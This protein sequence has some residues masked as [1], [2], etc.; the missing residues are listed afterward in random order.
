MKNE[1][2]VVLL[3][4][5][6]SG[7]G[8]AAA[9]LMAAAGM[10]VYA[11]SRRGT[12]ATES[13][14]IIPIRLDVNDEAATVAAI[15]GIIAKSG[16]LDAVVVN[17]GNG[18]AGAIEDTDDAEARFQFETCFFGALKTIRACLPVFRRQGH[19]RILTVTSV[20]AVIPIPYQGLYSSAKSAL[21][22]FTESLAIELKGSGI[23]CGSVLPGD[24]STGFTGARRLTAAAEREDSPYHDK[25]Q[26]YLR[27]IEHD[28]LEGMPAAKIAKA[29]LRQLQRRRMAMRLT[30]RIDYKAICLLARILPT[31]LK[32]W[33]IG[34]LYN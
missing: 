4:G 14:G 13:A 20:A 22:M 31:K 29:I 3:T 5:G 33:I 10:T 11:A 30:P 15:D 21:L 26:A 12:A 24:T 9:E 23:Q 28:E 7:I 25:F 16:R 17:A 2:K 8:A 27:K 34:L 1:T 6:S 19:G 18:I 32:L